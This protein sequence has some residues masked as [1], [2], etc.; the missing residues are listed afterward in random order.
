MGLRDQMRNMKRALLRWQNKLLSRGFQ[1]W[2]ANTV[3]R[4]KV[5][6]FERAARYFKNAGMARCFVNWRQ[7]AK[8]MSAR[9]AMLDK[10]NNRFSSE[11]MGLM[12]QLQAALRRIKELEDALSSQIPAPNLDNELDA[13]EAARRQ[14]QAELDAARKK[15]QALMSQGDASSADLDK[16]RRELQRAED[17]LRRANSLI[18]KLRARIKEL[19][20]ELARLRAQLANK[21]QDAQKAQDEWLSEQAR[22]KRLEQDEAT[23]LRDEA[24]RRKMEED[25]EAAR[26]RALLAK[27]NEDD[28]LEH[29]RKALAKWFDMKKLQALNSWRDEAAFL[30]R[31]DMIMKRVALRW[32]KDKAYKLLVKLRD[33]AEAKRIKDLEFQAYLTKTKSPSGRKKRAESTYVSPF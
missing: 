23:K 30:R 31:I 18:E 2:Y 19:E 24:N 4:P 3:G 21:A 1:T 32:K 8:A 28:D 16:A 13:A 10:L 25:A 26:R 9:D 27:K 22:R 20:E 5:D 17:E 7:I 6:H 11:T 15:L 29:I 14:A 33:Y 12:E